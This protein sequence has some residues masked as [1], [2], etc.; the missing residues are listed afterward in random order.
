MQKKNIF[1]IIFIFSS[2][3][4]F[5]K[6]CS[7]ISLSDVNLTVSTPVIIKSNQIDAPV[8]AD[9]KTDIILNPVDSIC[10]DDKN[11]KYIWSFGD[12]KKEEGKKVIHSYSQSG[13][14][15]IKLKGTGDYNIQDEITHF[16][17]IN[18][19]SPV[20]DFSISKEVSIPG[21]PVTFDARASFDPDGDELFYE[22]D[23]NDGRESDY[24]E[25]ITRSFNG[26][27]K[28]LV[29]LTVIDSDVNNPCADTILKELIIDTPP[30]ADFKIYPFL[31]YSAGDQITF[32]AALSFDPEGDNLKYYWD[33]GDSGQTFGP[34]T[35]N[36]VTH[37]YME[38]GI[39]IVNLTVSDYYGITHSKKVEI[40]VK[41]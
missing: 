15:K 30:E 20:A 26:P 13:I 41:N 8:S 5:T 16:I 7:I 34:T 31:D 24:R 38:S 17:T 35:L 23:F 22:W 3:F 9:K 10:N 4:F 12:G 39:Y 6:S 18:N 29:T 33:F 14:Y 19:N 25:L 37:T 1:L 32:D 40:F 27:G 21:S 11:T 28:Y 36:P 2:L